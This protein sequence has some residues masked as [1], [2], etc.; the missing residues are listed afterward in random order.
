VSLHARAWRWLS[1]EDSTRRAGLPVSELLAPLP[2]LMLALLVVND[3]VLKPSVA[4]AITGKLSD[5]AGLAVAPLILTAALDLL[6]AAAARLGAGVDPTLRAWKL[7]AA[8]AIVSAAF[9]AA[10]LS[11]AVAGA[12]AASLASVFGRAAIVTDPT[13]LLA[14]PAIA[15]AGYHG[16]TAIARI[17]AGRVAH[18][19]RR[20]RAG[21]P[22]AAPFADAISAGA[23][24]D[25]VAVLD[26]AVGAWLAGGPAAPV[27][28]ALARLRR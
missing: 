21:R 15:I 10:K 2:L 23:P 9:V 8:I 14:L 11:P 22:I 19:A 7:A 27:D 3:W 16:R 20:H 6:L 13:D 26:A 25:E 1:G 28:A 4:G 12:I 17:P 24:P 5:V 18:V